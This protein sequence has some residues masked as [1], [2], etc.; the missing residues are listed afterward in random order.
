MT[1]TGADDEQS[2]TDLASRA[3]R[4]MRSSLLHG[5]G[6]VAVALG[7]AQIAAYVV[8]VV[9]AR[10]LGPD[11]FGIVAA[12]LGLIL[13]GNVVALG[14]QAVIA[15]LIVA[16]DSTKAAIG[17]QGLRLGL[18]SAA[19]ICLAALAITPAMAWLL[20]L[21]NWWPLLWVA[22]TLAPLTWIGAQ[23]GVA[24]GRESFARLALIYAS[25]G[26]GRGIGGV[27][28]ALIGSSAAATLFGIMV[29]SVCGAFIG[30]IAVAPLHASDHR[31]IRPLMHPVAH[32]T[33]ALFALFLLTNIDVVLARAL[34]PADQAG[35][36]GVGSIVIKIAFWLPQFVGIIAFP[37]LADARRSR[38]LIITLA[39]VAGLGSVIVLTTAAVPGLV[40]AAVGGP[41]YE[42]LV[43]IVWLFALIGALFAL[44]QVLLLAR[45]AVDDR[46]AVLAIWIAVIAL[47]VNAVLV[48]PRTVT[49]IATAVAIAAALLCIIGLAYTLR[50]YRQG[51]PATSN[52]DHL[53]S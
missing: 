2:G 31:P 48:L 32:A 43:P 13:I 3:G 44:A 40:V 51:T 45:L 23:L 36:Y 12:M 38:T 37:R 29:G 9:A 11:E 50:E 16:S 52:D 1:T 6:L 8:N 17:S 46:R 14:L 25:V 30:R 35:D 34:L 33:H 27:V 21:S 24:Q 41:Q 10:A 5:T 20:D 22:L 47:G 39:T 26:L 53:P 4:L 19:A 42:S 49:G 28:G 7:I 18:A 15:R